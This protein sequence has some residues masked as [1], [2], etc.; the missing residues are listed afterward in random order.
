MHLKA[1][2]QC[3]LIC[4]GSTPIPTSPLSTLTPQWLLQHPKAIKSGS[5]LFNTH[6]QPKDSVVIKCNS[7]RHPFWSTN[8]LTQRGRYSA[9]NNAQCV[10]LQ[11]RKLWVSHLPQ[12]VFALLWAELV[13]SFGF[14][15][16]QESL[17]VILVSLGIVVG[18]VTKVAMLMYTFLFCRHGQSDPDQHGQS[19]QQE[20][21]PHLPCGTEDRPVDIR[22]VK[23]TEVLA[24]LRI[25]VERSAECILLVLCYTSPT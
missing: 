24:A 21:R 10:K 17:V 9:R 1:P 15:F 16:A 22:Y 23:P 6:T 19:C 4:Y 11:C 13:K 3:S 12:S 8:R 14:L 25:L 5:P 18:M 20:Q 7:F 2:L